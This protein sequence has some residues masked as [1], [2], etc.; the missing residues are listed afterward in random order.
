MNILI[1]SLLDLSKLESGITK[2]TFKYENVSKIVIRLKKRK[3]KFYIS[4]LE[5]KKKFTL[6]HDIDI[7]ND[8]IYYI[9]LYFEEDKIHAFIND[10]CETNDK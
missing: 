9:A 5:G 8:K 3:N 10:K 1:K 2:T 7:E 4:K 6:M